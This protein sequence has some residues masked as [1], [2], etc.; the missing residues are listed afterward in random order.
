MTTLAIKVDVDTHVGTRRGVPALVR[1]FQRFGV[2]ATFLFSLGPDQTG[3]AIFRVF[4]PGFFKKVQRTNVLE[5]Y[6]L[7]TL[8]YGTLLP[9]PHIGNRN[10][11]VLK[12]VRDQGFDV[13]IHA[14][15][16]CFWQDHI[17][18]LSEQAIADEFERAQAVFTQIFGQRASCAG[19]PG[20]QINERAWNVYDSQNLLFA[21][22][23]RGVSA[24]FPKIGGK[25][26]KTLQIPTTLPTL[27]EWLGRPEFPE[28]RLID[29]YRFRL[30]PDALNV[31]TIHAE[32]E[33]MRKLLFLETLLETL[34][35]HNVS[36]SSLPQIAQNALSNR[37]AI[38]ICE[39]AQQPIDGR[40]GNVC[41]QE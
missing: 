38:P 15:N 3:R 20:W 29:A 10:H 32:I 39:V 36:F 14:Y 17:H 28:N 5:L 18:D 35:R 27:D 8:L 1:L 22:D 13:G 40:S 24:F 9:S 37:T 34:L 19:A 21:S 4:R 26:F 30:K 2:P 16:H 41:M 6:G 25:I 12:A 33:G 23:T 7:R 31:L 11:D